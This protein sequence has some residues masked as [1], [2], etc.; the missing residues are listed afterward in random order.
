MAVLSCSSRV[1]RGVM[2]W[3]GPSAVQIPHPRQAEGGIS[4]TCSSWMKG[5][6]KGETRMPTSQTA[7]R[8]G[9]TTATE[10]LEF[11]GRVELT[12]IHHAGQKR[13]KGNP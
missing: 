9:S 7:Q 2:A 11:V 1:C 3:A 13:R 4:D 8:R 6:P 12:A 5:A 10:R